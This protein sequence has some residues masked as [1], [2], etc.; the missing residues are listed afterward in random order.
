MKKSTLAFFA[1]CLAVLGIASLIVVGLAATKYDRDH[2]AH[3]KQKVAAL[4]A[5]DH[6]KTVTPNNGTADST[7]KESPPEKGSDADLV[8]NTPIP[9]LSPPVRLTGN[10]LARYCSNPLVS[11]TDQ[12]CVRAALCGFMRVQV[13]LKANP[14]AYEY[15]IMI[16]CAALG[17]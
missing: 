9:D 1:L 15:Q 6:L 2:Q 5:A 7:K 13:R 8:K 4:E 16:G 12:D 17:L 14:S 3:Y 11:K 10:Q